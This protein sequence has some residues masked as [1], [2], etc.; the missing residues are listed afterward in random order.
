MSAQVIEEPELESPAPV[1]GREVVP[2]VPA[3]VLVLVETV[4][5]LLLSVVVTPATTA[6]LEATASEEAAADATGEADVTAEAA[7]EAEADSA[8]ESDASL[9]ASAEAEASGDSS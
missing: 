5:V 3:A 4:F 2:P 8:G 9:E 6:G 7:A 1:F